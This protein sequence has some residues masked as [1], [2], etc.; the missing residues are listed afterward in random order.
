MIETPTQHP[1]MARVVCL[2]ALALICLLG[3][4]SNERTTSTLPGTHPGSWMDKSSS[5]FH[6]RVVAAG[7]PEGCRECHGE[8]LNGGEVQ[9]SCI[10]CHIEEGACV[11]CHGGRDNS[12]GAP[13]FGLRGDFYDTTIAV[14]AHT[15]HLTAS[16]IAAAV[17]CDACHLVPVIASDSGHIG[18]DSIAEIRW[19]GISDAGSAAWDREDRTC[20]NTY[21]HGAFSGGNGVNAPIWTATSQAEC[22]SCHDVGDDP[23]SLGWK[24]SFHVE[25]AG[26]GC[27]ECHSGVVDITLKITNVNQHVNGVVDTLTRDTTVCKACHGPGVNSCTACHGGGDN[28]TG[29][30]PTGLRGETETTDLAVGAHSTHLEDGEIAAAL[31]CGSCHTVPTNV[32][33]F[34]HLGPD[35]VAEISFNGLAG[36]Q[37]EWDRVAATCQQTY[38]HG[39]FAAG[40]PFNIPIWTANGQAVCGSCHDV[41]VNPWMLGGVHAFHILSAG[42]T[43]GDCHAGVADTLGH[44]IDISLHVNGQIDT[45]IRDQDACDVCHGQ[46]QVGCTICHGGVD[47]QTGAPPEGIEGETATNEL[48]VGAHTVHVDG[49]A[50]ADA[51]P[52]NACHVTPESTLDDGHLG[53]DSVAE[54][55]WGGISGEQAVWDRVVATCEQTYCHGNFAGGDANNRPVWTSAGQA[56]C[57]SCHDTGDDPADLGW[58][59]EFHVVSAGL[60]CS[61]CHADV[62]DAQLTIIDRTLHVDGNVNTRTRDEAVCDVCHQQG[63]AYCTECHGGADNQTGAPPSGIEGE[64]ASTDLA[65]GAH[66]AHVEASTLAGAIDCD[67]CHTKPNAATDAGHFGVDSVA[68]ITWGAVAGD[69]STWNRGSATCSN[70]YC[71]GNFTGGSGANAP[72]WTST[73]QEFCGSCHDVGAQASDLRWKHQFHVDVVSLK[74]GDCHAAVVDTLLNIVDPSLHVNGVIDTLTR[75]DAVCS[76]CH[77]AGAGT[78]TYCHGGSDNQSGAPPVG[79]EGETATTQ[80][81]VGAHTIH[82]EGGPM[83]AGFSCTE[84]HVTPLAWDDPEHL[85]PDFIAEVT[86]GPIAGPNAAW[87]RTDSSCTDVY[88]HGDFNGGNGNQSPPW[89]ESGLNLCG[90]CH[91]YGAHPARLSGRHEKHVIDKDIECYQCHSTTVDVNLDFVDKWVHV[92]GENTISFSSGQGDWANGECTN[93]GC[94]GKE[95]W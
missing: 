33:D 22:G 61:E 49:G 9:V 60:A 70:T 82:L 81:A 2:V 24:H 15:E 16:E 58:E 44:I 12:T 18:V 69:Q 40:D 23:Q 51:I 43:C 21:C 94:H 5:D 41:G 48:A 13:P 4:C 30:P 67:E 55:T 90:S 47:N 3:G 10:D 85:G 64:I 45:L 6:G 93:T 8:D 36:E 27:I 59:H 26:L 84:C 34:G 88:C 35:S 39:N 73:G 57:G 77:G 65:V 71:H 20:R 68:E 28:A 79:I 14:G 7:N 76:S 53:D 1:H 75:D 74:C 91:D 31:P 72:V 17:S 25:T 62:V 56:E 87:S 37:S 19:H 83:A 89:T 86:F 50:Q 42:F 80:L 11:T 54:I 78:C 66:T 32:Q 95:D 29:A 38:C 46:G 52:C 92:D 63:T